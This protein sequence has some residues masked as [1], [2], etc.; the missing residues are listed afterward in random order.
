MI[1]AAVV[2]VG[3]AGSRV[4]AAVDSTTHDMVVAA[5]AMVENGSRVHDSTSRLD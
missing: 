2:K 5:V 1:V 4:L 3:T